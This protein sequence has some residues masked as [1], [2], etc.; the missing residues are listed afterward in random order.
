MLSYI[1]YSFKAAAKTNTIFHYGKNCARRF[2]NHK[3]FS[4]FLGTVPTYGFRIF[5]VENVRSQNFMKNWLSEVLKFYRIRLLFQCDTYNIF[6]NLRIVEFICTQDLFHSTVFTVSINLN[7][8]QKLKNHPAYLMC[9]CCH[10]PDEKSNTDKEDGW[11]L[12][13]LSVRVALRTETFDIR[14]KT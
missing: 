10:E 9:M 2:V 7:Q 13:V 8:Q 12:R 1:Y 6:W 14:F 5:I 3:Y 4:N 11:I